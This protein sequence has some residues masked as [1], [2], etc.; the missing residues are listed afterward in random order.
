MLAL[1]DS[2]DGDFAKAQE[3]TER[4]LAIARATGDLMGE[5]VELGNLGVEHHLRGD[6]TGEIDDYR[7]AADAYER[8]LALAQR[9]GMREHEV[10]S[11]ANLAQ[12][13]VRLGDPHRALDLAASSLDVALEHD[14][15]PQ[16][17]A[18]VIYHAD[19]LWSLG[20]HD[21]ALAHIGM[22]RRDP[23]LGG[24]FGIEL[25]RILERFGCSPDELERGLAAGAAL[26]LDDVVARILTPP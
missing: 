25:P 5:A 4:A 22:A 2:A 8:S 14:L 17:L 26:T 9:L 23:Q 21:M 16:V 15:V 11:L 19:A 1:L 13:N 20:E 3:N 10:V 18:A 6:A 24:D 7:A 12:L